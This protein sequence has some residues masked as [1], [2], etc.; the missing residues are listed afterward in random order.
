MTTSRDT[1]R[2]RR[3]EHDEAVELRAQRKQKELRY[4][5]DLPSR[6]IPAGRY[7]V[8]NQVRPAAMLGMNGFRVWTQNTD[9]NLVECRC[10]FGGW[11]N[12]KRFR[13]Y[14]VAAAVPRG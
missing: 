6:A 4:C 14:R 8:H 10:D 13:H 7:L 3:A 5:K 12:A 9:D 2:R 1:E 11:N